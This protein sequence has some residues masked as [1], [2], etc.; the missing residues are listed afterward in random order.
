MRY[1]NL[2]K[3]GSGE[4]PL[5]PLTTKASTG[6]RLPLYGGVVALVLIVVITAVVTL[7]QLRQ[8]AEK[9]VASTT[10]NLF[11]VDRAN[12]QQPDRHGRC[13]LAGFIQRNSPSNVAWRN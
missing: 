9:R 1:P 6:Y 5:R 7:I 10:Q 11:K 8:Q 4:A 12:V 3:T 13:R 2:S